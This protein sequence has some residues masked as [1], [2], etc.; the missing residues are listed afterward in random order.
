MRDLINKVFID[1]DARVMFLICGSVA[2][3]YIVKGVASYGQEVILAPIRNAIVTSTQ[4]KI[5]N[6]LLAQDVPFFKIARRPIS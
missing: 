2:L 4:Q 6:A 5:F 3:I 1:R